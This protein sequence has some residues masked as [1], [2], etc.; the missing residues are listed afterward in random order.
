M[1][2][3]KALILAKR[4]FLLYCVI[5]FSGLGLDFGIYSMVLGFGL[6][7]YQIANALGYTCGTMLTFTLNSLYNFRVKDRIFLRFLIFAGVATV[8]WS[9]SAWLLHLLVEKLGFDRY[10]AKM[11]TVFVVVFIQYNLNRLVSFRKAS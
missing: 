2:E 3:L 7:D 11:T 9:V 8:G 10:L 5:G 4:Q 1:N 6:G